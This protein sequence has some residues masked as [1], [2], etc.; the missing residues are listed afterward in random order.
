MDMTKKSITSTVF[1]P[2][3]IFTAMFVGAGFISGGIVHLGDGFNWWD[4]SLILIGIIL[5]VAGSYAQELR[6]NQNNIKK[7]GIVLFL[8]Y[9]LLL[10]IGIGMAS[11]GT[12]HFVDT[13]AYSNYLIPIGLF[14][15]VPA[16]A[17]KQNIAL[18]KN[19]WIKLL[20]ASF[21]IAV[22]LFFVLAAI[23]GSLPDFH[24]DSGKHS[25]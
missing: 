13:P 16:F 10:S 11:G 4:V 12:Q 23:N 6:N 15:G 25:H 24:L 22:A 14:L 5:F 1:L 9:S 17:L 7:E 2:F 18:Q 19:D 21:L 3:I 8:F 20:F